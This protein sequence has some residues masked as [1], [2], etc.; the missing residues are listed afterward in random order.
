M[1]H[2]RSCKCC[3]SSVDTIIPVVV[4]DG[5]STDSFA[6]AAAPA[7][8]ADPVAELTAANVGAGGGAGAGAGAGAEAGAA[9][10]SPTWNASSFCRRSSSIDPGLSAPSPLLLVAAA[11][12]D[13]LG[14]IRAG[15]EA[16]AAGVAAGVGTAGGLAAGVGSADT[17]AL[18]S[19]AGVAAD[20][21]AATAGAAGGNRVAV[22]DSPPSAPSESTPRRNLLIRSV[23]STSA[24]IA[25]SIGHAAPAA[26]Q[27]KSVIVVLIRIAS[28]MAVPPASFVD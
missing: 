23:L 15:A 24:R 20:D 10:A 8:N 2:T 1:R 28:A 25:A 26:A 11:A 4:G 16:A 17:P 3:S 12:A 18:L 7:A 27:F 22:A 9:A 21:A 14:I 5:V 6:S 13:W 19:F